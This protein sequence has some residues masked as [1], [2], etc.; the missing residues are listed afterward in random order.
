MAQKDQVLLSGHPV[1]FH[2]LNWRGMEGKVTSLGG[3]QVTEDNNQ[4]A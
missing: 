2:V 1:P 4:I 3:E